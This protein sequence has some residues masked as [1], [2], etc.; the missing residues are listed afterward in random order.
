MTPATILEHDSIRQSITEWALDYG[1]TPA[2]IIGRLERGMSIGNA[3]TTPMKVGHRGQRLP[4]FSRKQ[5]KSKVCNLPPAEHWKPPKPRQHKRAHNARLIEHNGQT[6]TVAEWSQV[7]GVSI[8]KIYGRLHLGWDFGDALVPGDARRRRSASREE[9]ER[10]GGVDPRT[11]QSRLRRGWPLELAMTE[12]PG[13]RMGRF[14]RGRPG[15]P[16]DFAPFEGTGAG[17][18]AQETQNI[19]FSGIDA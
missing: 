19:T 18:T 1:I 15:V 16:S 8:Q 13:A 11:V 2:I 7:S 9:L 12:P 10:D 17:R 14:A 4:I 5:N 3:I 6:L